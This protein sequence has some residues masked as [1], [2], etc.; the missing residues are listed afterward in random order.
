M[1]TNHLS[2]EA[3]IA[4]VLRI[5]EEEVTDDLEYR[6]IMEWDSLAHVHLMIALEEAYEIEIDIDFR[7]TL[8]SVAAIRA[9]IQQHFSSNQEAATVVVAQSND[10]PTVH[11]GL[12]GVV[13][14]RTHTTLID[15]KAGRLFYRGY[16][17]HDLVQH[18]TYEEVAYLLLHG[19]LPTQEQ[20]GAFQE[21]LLAAREIP[22]ELIGMISILRDARPIEV[23]RTGV[24]ALAVF[25]PERD[26]TSKD[27]LHKQ[28]IRLIAQLPTILATHHAIRNGKEPVS[29]DPTLSHA[30][31]FLYMMQGV[32]PS[33]RAVDVMDKLFILHADHGSNASAFTTRVVAGT[34]SDLY[35]SLTAAI[36]A[37]AGALHGG[38][39]ENVMTMLNEIGEPER[40]AE[41]VAHLTANKQP[42]MGFGHRVYETADPRATHIRR[43]AQELS[44]EAGETNLWGII[45]AVLEAM[46]P[47]SDKGIDVNVDFYA[48]IIY[49]VLGLEQDEFVSAFAIARMPGWIAQAQE[50]IENNILIR[51]LL[52]YVGEIDLPY[53]RVDQRS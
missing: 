44:A 30:A 7:I 38:A 35:A 9:Y 45:E 24:S 18:S 4:N 11:R 12:A 14:D 31:N 34:R 21:A 36:A 3:L 46:K 2:V 8:T 40:A 17:I 25:D 22:E 48:S 13:F 50:Q 6:A 15:G 37:F 1:S 27:A 20:L 26:D 33:E 10:Q 41:Y 43:M 52:H 29:P 23:L 5:P 16:S 53:L 49:H 19:V 47:Y 51:P 32:K 28:G 42:V 39:V